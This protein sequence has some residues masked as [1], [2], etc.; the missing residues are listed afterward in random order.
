MATMK[1]TTKTMAKPK[2]KKAQSGTTVGGTRGQGKLGPALG[3]GTTVTGAAALITK[4][5]ADKVKAKKAA[6]A[7]EEKKKAT[8]AAKK[9]TMQKMGGAAKYKMGGLTKAQKGIN[10]AGQAY[11]NYVPG[12]T[13]SDTLGTDDIRF[14]YPGYAEDDSNWDAK[15]KMLDMT[16]GEDNPASNGERAKQSPQ[17]VSEYAKQLKKLYG[18]SKMGGA[19]TAKYKKG[20][21]VK[22]QD[23][24]IT[25]SKDKTTSFTGTGPNSNLYYKE[26]EKRK[27]VFRPGSTDETVRTKRT[28][29]QHVGPNKWK[30]AGPTT[31][32]KSSS[33]ETAD[34]YTQGPTTTRKAIFAIGKRSHKTGGAAKATYKTG[35]M[36]NPN[37]KVSALKKAGS[38][39]VKP[40]VNPKATPAKRATGRTGG[41]STA[42]RTAKPKK[43][44]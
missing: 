20:G 10:T 12:A 39:G 23:G 19:A 41:T 3:I 33:T 15:K 24:K 38:K 16:Y 25:R 43:N 11:M 29:Y 44:K 2:L 35:G 40:N 27:N 31:V 30:K 14:R 7:E 37:A 13:A 21:L 28:P 9:M 34:G 22:A 17:S 5:I 36:V 26:K 6:K 32:T 1:K 4:M 18:K 42:P 8:T